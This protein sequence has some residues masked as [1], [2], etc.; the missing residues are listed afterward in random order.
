[1][2]KY[3]MQERNLQEVRKDAPI[4]TIYRSEKNIGEPKTHLSCSTPLTTLEVAFR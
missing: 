1:M 2:G 3:R 4:Y